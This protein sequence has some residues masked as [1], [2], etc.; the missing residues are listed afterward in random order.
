MLSRAQI[1]SNF[2]AMNGSA[3]PSAAFWHTVVVTY[4]G[5]KCAK[6]CTSKIIWSHSRTRTQIVTLS[7]S[8]KLAKI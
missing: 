7:M 5:I 1:S 4:G 8:G 6:Q 3:T 2:H